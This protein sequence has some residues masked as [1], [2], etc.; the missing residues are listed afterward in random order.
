MVQIYNTLSVFNLPPRS[1]PALTLIL[2]SHLFWSGGFD[3]WHPAKKQ[4]DTRC[5]KHRR[6]ASTLLC[7]TTPLRNT[8]LHT[9]AWEHFTLRPTLHPT[10]LATGWNYRRFQKDRISRVKF[11]WRIRGRCMV[12]LRPKEGVNAS[13]PTQQNLQ[14]SVVGLKCRLRKLLPPRNPQKQRTENH[15]T[16]GPTN[17]RQ[18]WRQATPKWK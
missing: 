15:K 2:H 11:A 7:H 14:L 3:W 8:A 10:Q 12:P 5:E 6:I 1:Q 16:K 13:A 17:K 9:H 4:K 18:I